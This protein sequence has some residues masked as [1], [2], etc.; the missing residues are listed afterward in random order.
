MSRMT[1]DDLL[2]YVCAESDAARAFRQEVDQDRTKAIRAYL[3]KP[4]GTELAGRSQVVASDVFD[5]VEGILPEL[6]EV[7]VSSDK[8]V[9]FDPVSADDEE[10][11][12]QATRACN[13]VFYKQNNG[14]HVLY[15]AAKDALLLRT[16]AIKWYWDERRTPEWVTYKAVDE[17]QL[18]AY[19]VANPE[20][21][22]VS[23]EPYVP[24]DEEKAQA[25]QMGMEVPPKVTVRIKTVKKRGTVKL[26]NIPPD[27]LEV[28]RRHNSPLLDECPYVCHKREVTLSDVRQMGYK[29]T[30]EDIKGAAN[31]EQN[32]DDWRQELDNRMRGFDDTEED[33]SMIR[34]WLREEYVL[35][36]F[37]GDGIAERRKVV[38]LGKKLLENE[39]FS[40]VP[41][42]GWSPYLLTHRFEGMSAAD[43]V[44]DFQRI[45]TDIWRNQL[46]NLELA[47][48]QET[49]VLTDAQGNPKANID[50][51]LNRRPG[52]VLREHVQGAIRPYVERWQGI[53][54]MPMLEAM[55]RAK[56]SRTGFIPTIEGLDADA[57]S[58]T[59]TQV[60]KESNRS[61]KRL[62]LMARIMAECLVAPTMRGI[63]KTLTD[64]CMEPLSFKL[65]GTFVAYDP[66]EWRDQYN[67]TVNVGIGTG[68]QMQQGA[69]LMQ[70]GAAQM[71]LMPTP[72]GYLVTAENIFNLHARMAENAGFKNPGEFIS[73]PKTVQ[74]PQPIPDPKMQLEQM[75]LQADAQK[76]QAQTQMD[77]QRFQAEAQMN[78]QV[79]SAKQ[80]MQARQRQ[81][82]LEQQAQVKALEAQYA[83]RALA[84]QLEA[85]KWKAKLDAEVKLTIASKPEA[86]VSALSEQIKALADSAAEMP[87]IDRDE[88]S[89]EAVRVRKGSKA[90]GI[91]RDAQGRAI[92]LMPL[93][94]TGTENA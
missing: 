40:H 21:E 86:N 70:M 34:G 1:E 94:E 47:N 49:V 9:V 88:V 55:D 82:E 62:K 28:S 25:E 83:E 84:A 74:R 89:G 68:D 4:Y 92:G 64:Y 46:D 30:V 71:A 67:M 35:V 73:D 56:Q 18:A 24:T 31:D 3:R 93:E 15:V 41:M 44:E 69:M 10:G 72:H 66:Q 43:L 23:R 87:E 13:H 45:N 59:A 22:V 39:E 27:E 63:F 48:N 20:A 54:A 5:T 36:D 26:C 29:V 57:L 79:E 37:D 42:A 75:K 16:G 51:V 38:R 8:A 53:E 11:A 85:D 65:N 90:Y 50:D 19:L 52:G 91:N 2:R 12:E 60:S 61:Q 14:F 80:E 81:L 32:F 33:E 77:A 58:K 7:F 78:M 6:I 76:F 17:V